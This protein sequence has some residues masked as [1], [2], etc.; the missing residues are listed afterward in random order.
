[1]KLYNDNGL[2]SVIVPVY[3]VEK[4]LNR[5]ID[6]IVNQ[7]YKNIEIILVDDGSK[8][9]SGEICDYYAKNNA[10]VQVIHKKN[11][12]LSDARN[13]GIKKAH[14]DYISFVDSDD[15]LEKDIYEKCMNRNKQYNA[16]IINF[17][18]QINHSDGKFYNQNIK[19]EKILYDKEGLIYL[20]SFKNLDI[21]ACN[22]IFK[23]CL[24][25]DIEFPFGKLCEDCYVMFKLFNKA[26]VVLVIP[27]IGYHYFRRKGS[28]TISENINLDYLYAYEE[29]MNYFRENISELLYIAETSYVFANITTFNNAIMKNKIQKS[30]INETRK[31]VRKYSKSVYKNGY[32]SKRKKIQFFIFNRLNYLYK[33]IIRIKR[34]YGNKY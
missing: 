25:A 7:T 30:L 17:A 24:F 16:D 32:L 11:G 6:S 1:M 14:G 13:Q 2:I 31:N 19:K 8:D 10:K 34:K 21:S 27:Y 23:T 28:I 29:Q 15:W 20:N 3:N 33:I 5:C 12:G 4:Y 18:I 9:K 22:K 26:K